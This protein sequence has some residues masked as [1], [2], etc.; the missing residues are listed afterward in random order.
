M[1]CGTRVEEGGGFLVQ[2]DGKWMVAHRAGAC[3][4]PS[5][6]LNQQIHSE[7]LARGVPEE[8]VRVQVKAA[9]W[10]VDEDG[11]WRG[12]ADSD[13]RQLLGWLRQYEKDLHDEKVPV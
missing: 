12:I 8:T 11:D 7:M 2:K 4:T 5:A 3:V 13:R 6:D 9:G 10:A 1:N